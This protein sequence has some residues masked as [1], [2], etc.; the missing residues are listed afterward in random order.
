VAALRQSIVSDPDE[1]AV[2][3]N[4]YSLR[5]VN[6]LVL[7]VA[8]QTLARAAEGDSPATARVPAQRTAALAASSPGA[9]ILRA[10]LVELDAEGRYVLLNACA[11]QLRYPNAHTLF[12]MRF[13]LATFENPP[14]FPWAAGGSA[15]GAADVL[16]EQLARVLLERIIVHRP[17]P[18]GVLAAI[19]ELVRNPANNLWAHPFVHASPDVEKLFESVARSCMGGSL[20]QGWTGG[21]GTPTA[22][23]AA[24][25]GAA[26]E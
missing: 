4:R 20:P 25:A 15:T 13:L 12:F 7:F 8:Q 21:A 11:A 3:S 19:T 5:A 24:V 22:A 10:L 1:A 23:A 9:D 14:A 26:Q 6:G 18:W 16:R 2:T 17:H